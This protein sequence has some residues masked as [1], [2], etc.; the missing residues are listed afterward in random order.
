MDHTLESIWNYISHIRLS[1]EKSNR[2]FPN[3]YNKFIEHLEW[4]FKS[5]SET[6]RSKEILY[7]GRIYTAEDK[8]DKYN[9]PEKYKLHDY[10]GYDA[11][12]SFVNLSSQWPQEGRMNPIGIPCLYTAKDIDTCI[13]E[14]CP[15]LEELISIAE[16][17]V[18]EDLKIA[19]LSKSS[20]EGTIEEKFRID[21]SVY[22]QELICQGGYNAKDYVFPQFIAEAC[23]HMG[24][25]GIAYRSKYAS[26]YNVAN[27]KGVNV[28]IFNFQ[29]CEPVN[30]KLFIVK[31]VSVTSDAL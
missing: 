12:K 7:R 22:V 28:T 19:D 25:D 10:V 18:L 8:W 27:G 15:G 5:N 1:L 30:S 6:I 14:L 24:Y 31:E 29:K 4:I 2:C 21:L 16:I 26:R 17:K 23:K 9:H 13:K 20:A 3:D 11:E